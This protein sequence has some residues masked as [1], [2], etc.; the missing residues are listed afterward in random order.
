MDWMFKILNSFGNSFPDFAA[1]QKMSVWDK[2]AQL[3]FIPQ[4]T[5]GVYS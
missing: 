2:G 4:H 1:S 5:Q 3:Y